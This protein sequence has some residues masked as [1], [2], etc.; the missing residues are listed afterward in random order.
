MVALRS[1][2]TAVNLAWAIAEHLAGSDAA[3]PRTLFATH[4]HEL[5]QLAATLP[6]VRNYNVLVREVGD[7]VLFY[8]EL[9]LKLDVEGTPAIFLASG[10]VL[11]G[12]APPSKLARYLKSGK[13]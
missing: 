10:E 11:P 9:G 6:A 13:W 1:R 7:Q 8:R 5:V 12:Y 2:P 4:Y 3:G